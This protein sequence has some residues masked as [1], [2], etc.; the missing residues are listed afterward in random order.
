MYLDIQINK[1]SAE[2]ILGEIAKNSPKT[3]IGHTKYSVLNGPL[4][5]TLVCHWANG[6]LVHLEIITA[7]G[8]GHYTISRSGRITF[9]GRR[10]S[11]KDGNHIITI[12]PEKVTFHE[13][14]WVDNPYPPREYPH[15]VEGIDSRF[16]MIRPWETMDDWCF[17]GNKFHFSEREFTRKI[18]KG[19]TLTQRSKVSN[20][21]RVH[22]KARKERGIKEKEF[23]LREIERNGTKKLI[24]IPVG[25]DLNRPGWLTC[26][27]VY[28]PGLVQ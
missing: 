20:I 1:S 23:R 19:Y 9:K 15:T 17:L 14:F 2:E 7:S 28:W 24:A 12:G 4:E 11:L 25:V 26:Y 5:L 21:V 13:P 6:T 16:A 10:N 18:A 22:D 3:T 27:E 8:C